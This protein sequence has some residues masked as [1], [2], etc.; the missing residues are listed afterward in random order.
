MD[1]NW[2]E[3]KATKS[4]EEQT[5]NLR[6]V[7]LAPAFCARAAPPTCPPRLRLDTLGRGRGGLCLGW[8]HADRLGQR[9][10]TTQILPTC[11]G[12]EPSVG[13]KELLKSWP[14]EVTLLKEPAA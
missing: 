8:I 10:G 2:V 7:P 12:R 1:P 11:L 14:S 4:S 9:E 6:G 13:A 5:N 3:R